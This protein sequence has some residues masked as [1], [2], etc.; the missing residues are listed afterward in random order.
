MFKRGYIEGNFIYINTIEREL[1]KG[2]FIEGNNS[3][4]VFTEGF[5]VKTLYYDI[6]NCPES[7]DT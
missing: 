5:L 4:T 1:K 3:N 7:V 2:L 6:R